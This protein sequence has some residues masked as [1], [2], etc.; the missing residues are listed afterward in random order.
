MEKINS[1][2]GIYPGCSLEGTASG[3][4][5]SLEKVLDALE[6]DYGV[7][8]DWNCC[9]ATSA[10]ALDHSLYLA[11]AARNLQRSNSVGFD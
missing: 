3:F 2:T 9:G 8:E 10:H 11:L 7:M 1:K 5:T 6:A 4:E